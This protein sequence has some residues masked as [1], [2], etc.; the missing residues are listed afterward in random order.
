M[1]D[2]NALIALVLS[3]IVVGLF[4][5]LKYYSNT[6]G[7]NPETFEMKKFLPI[8]TLSIVISVTLALVNGVSMTAEG[9]AEYMTANFTLVL[10]ANTLWT[11]L[12]KKYPSLD[13]IFD[14]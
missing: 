3:A 14:I 10:F 4:A 8:M 9:I 13:S 2:V 6:V 12:A 7:S 1:I 11:I 5:A